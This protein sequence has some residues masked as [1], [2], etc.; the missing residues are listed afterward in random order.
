M[1]LVSLR[2]RN[3]LS[4]LD[5]G[6][7]DFSGSDVFC[8]TGANGQGKSAL[9]DAIT[10]ALFGQARGGSRNQER[11]ISDGSD[12]AEVELIFEL[13]GSTYRIVRSRTKA[14]AEAQ[15]MVDSDG[16]WKTLAGDTLTETNTNIESALRLNC[17]TLVASAFFVQGMAEDFVNR[18]KTKKHEIFAKLLGLDV[19]GDL[20]EVA[21]GIAKS[22]AQKRK[23]AADKLEQLDAIAKELQQTREDLTKA[24]AVDSE[25]NSRLELVQKSLEV[26]R[27]EYAGFEETKKT[28]VIHELHLSDVKKRLPSDEAKIEENNRELKELEGLLALKSKV[29][30]ALAEL[31]ELAEQEVRL[32]QASRVHSNLQLKLQKCAGRLDTKRAQAEVTATN[33]LKGTAAIESELSEL[34]KLEPRLIQLET[35]LKSR[36][37]LES[38][39]SAVQGEIS[40]LLQE[41][42]SLGEMLKGLET[43]LEDS[44]NG[45]QL[46]LIEGA[47]CPV[48]REPLLNHRR[49]DLLSEGS[50]RE[51]F[52]KKE[53]ESA[54]G[55]R[56]VVRKEGERLREEEVRLRKS[57]QELVGIDS[58]RAEL[59]TAISRGKILK[60]QHRQLTEQAAE[61][62]KALE[63]GSIGTEIS[64]EMKSIS[65]ELAALGFESSTH[66]ALRAQIKSL[67]DNREIKGRLDAAAPRRD[68]LRREQDLLID[69]TK[70][71]SLNLAQ[72]EIEITGLRSALVDSEECESALNEVLKD[73]SHLAG[74][75]R[76]AAA[77]VARLGERAA[78]LESR[79]GELDSARAVESEAAALNKRAL[80]L[81]QAF[82]RGGIPDRIISN[83]LPEFEQDVSEILGGLTE[84]E[85]SV[86]IALDKAT[87]QNG[88]QDAF[89]VLVH[90]ATGIRDFE[91][92]SGGERFRIAF[93]LRLGLS[94]LLARRSGARVQTLVIDEGF[95]S[96][97]PA[98]RQE[99]VRAIHAARD[100]FSKVIV[101]THLEE[102]KEE[103]PVQLRVT[104][105]EVDGAQVSLVS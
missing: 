61:L 11:L 62:T 25:L 13:D 32:S 17:E 74:L 54:S 47:D 53:I 46:L 43:Q 85:M 26:R 31:Q 75:A 90:H 14:K 9:L 44:T 23:A 73:E 99:L 36:L 66:E 97:D 45:L 5:S 28:L 65:G 72:R 34:T 35:K 70:A 63:D 96:Q 93:A 77:A 102:L 1:K 91:Y 56:E 59:R 24:K 105:D 22:A 94:R 4:Y 2:L 68:S 104:K 60:E 29:E 83:A 50:E 30:I 37:V 41:H 100:E 33:H 64:A 95:G 39:L 79:C 82:G 80:R 57:L 8:L 86:R 12:R 10:W 7:I 92:F 88:V 3:F 69:A 87:K 49:Q 42:A 38:D 98:G 52:L 67:E 21:R 18:T 27:R 89:D 71:G 48:C 84:H 20:E 55:R 76:D 103:F 16:A 15:F 40:E 6:V 81:A 19:Y 101:I 78:G 58:Q 51:S